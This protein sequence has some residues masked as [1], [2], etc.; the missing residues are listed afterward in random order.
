M[1][2][3]ERLIA[4]DKEYSELVNKY[5]IYVSSCCCAKYAALKNFDEFMK[6]DSLNQAD[7]SLYVK[8]LEYGSPEYLS[9]QLDDRKLYFERVN[10]AWANE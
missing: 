8:G 6:Y 3:L 5:L 1:N 4:F 2:E 7:L 10:G 9:K